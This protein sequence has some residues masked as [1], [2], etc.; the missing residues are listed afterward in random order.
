MHFVNA[1]PRPGCYYQQWFSIC[2]WL[3]TWAKVRIQ[4]DWFRRKTYTI[5]IAYFLISFEVPCMSR[6]ARKLL[7]KGTGAVW[8]K[9]K[10]AFIN[11]DVDGHGQLMY[12]VKPDNAASRDEFCFDWCRRK[13]FEDK[14]AV[15][16]SLAEFMISQWRETRLA[17][18]LLCDL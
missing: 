15:K 16:F 9:G 10:N 17:D 1:T 11:P 6:Y 2:F 12:Q 13:C 18:W 8:R 14:N 4:P 5:K 7:R 3:S